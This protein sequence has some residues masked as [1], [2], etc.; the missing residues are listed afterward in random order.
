MTQLTADMRC[1]YGIDRH[2]DGA[3]DDTGTHLA[4]KPGW[5]SANVVCDL[6]AK[7]LGEQEAWTI[8]PIDGKQAPLT[9][10]DLDEWTAQVEASTHDTGHWPNDWARA[11]LGALVGQSWP[12]RRRFTTKEL[13]GLLRQARQIL[14]TNNTDPTAG[15]NR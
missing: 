12:H 11:G 13:L 2:E 15:G 5:T 7:W 1:I 4:R 6:H 8:E 14:E 9:A 3:I 10:A